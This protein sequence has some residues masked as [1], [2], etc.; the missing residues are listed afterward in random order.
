MEE[1]IINDA[2]KKNVKAVGKDSSIKGLDFII[3]STIALV[4]FL[5]PLFFTNLVAQGIGFEK[6]IL[7]YFLVLVG[8]V[9]WVT[10]GVVQGELNLKRTPLDWPI[11]LLLIIFGLSTFFS[12]SM[13]D[14]LIGSY[15][16]PAKGLAAIIIYI[17][18]YYLVVNNLNAKRI[19]I[20]FWSLITATG[21]LVIFSLLQL[22]NIFILPLA[23]T[24]AQNFNPLGSLSGLTAFIVAVL[25]LLIIAMAQVQEIFPKANKFLIYAVKTICGLV[26]AGA[27]I[28]LSLLNGFTFWP[29]AIVSIVIVLMFFLAKI[30]KITNNN[31]LIPLI[32]FLLLIILLVLGNFNVAGL[33]LP[34]EVSLSR[35]ASWQIAQGAIKEHPLL[36]SGPSTFYYDFSKFRDIKFNASPLWN[37]NF[38]S[39]S[40]IIFEL[41]AT[42]GAIGA[43]IFIILILIALSVS[44]LTILKTEDREVSSILLGLFSSLVAIILYL[45]L[46]SQSNSLLI[47]F[48]IISVFAFAAGLVM[49]PDKVK[50]LKLS[51][52]ASAKYALALA[53]IFLCVSAGVVVLFTLGLKMYLADESAQQATLTSDLNIKV[54]DLD[55]AIDLA[56]YQDVYYINNA[57]NYMALANQAATTNKSQVDINNY[58]SKAINLG[59]QAIALAPNRSSNNELLAL[60]YENASFY[61]Q[62]ALDWADNSYTKEMELDPNNPTPNFRL[63]LVNMARANA[64]SDPEQKKFYINAAIK[65]YE[66][67]IAKKGDLAA[68]YYGEAIAYEKLNNLDSAIDQLKKANLS[69]S[70]NLDYRFELGRLFF[71]RGVT[72]PNL[73]QNAS[74]QIAA[75]QVDNSNSTTTSANSTAVSVNPT[76]PTGATVTRND[77]INIAEQL[78]LSILTVNENYVN[79][80]YSLAVLYQKIGEKDKARIMVNSLL[81]ILQDE[82]QKSTIREQFQ[83]LL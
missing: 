48:V 16:N 31:L 7:F 41:A 1:K 65:D 3:V 77:D 22:K 60:I 24:H 72:Q 44:F 29:I 52:R 36:G 64:E 21:L 73:N 33:N 68:A 25:P 19:K 55:K 17:L 79:A 70:T 49:Y 26:V 23:F 5:C 81:N 20:I 47:T 27:L 4:F 13:K 14:S 76:Q 42:I 46:F 54:A 2:P 6:M 40:G 67:A 58:L 82:S 61:T 66:Q 18:F 15:G 38:D 59:K 34:A 69:D 9:A 12:V 50:V 8:I 45:L 51:F 80:R 35:S 30:I 53:A 43:L 63:G 56:P 75:S 37:V 83:S 71:N 78:F 11:L 28:I 74:Q 62:G 39:A 57:N 32:V 10:K